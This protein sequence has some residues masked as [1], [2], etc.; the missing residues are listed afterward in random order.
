MAAAGVLVITVAFLVMPDVTLRK[1]TLHD[2]FDACAGFAATGDLAPLAAYGVEWMQSGQTEVQFAVPEGKVRMLLQASDKG[3]NYDV[4]VVVGLLT[5]DVNKLAKPDLPWRDA[6]TSVGEWFAA[7]SADPDAEPWLAA[8]LAPGDSMLAVCPSDGV[9]YILAGGS[10]N[11]LVASKTPTDDQAMH[12]A[13]NRSADKARIACQ[14]V[15]D[16][17]AAG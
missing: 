15:A 9:G 14:M 5:R 1:A 6:K 11:L 8:L 3:G 17:R 10:L 16:V 2:L 4:C 13:A 12:F 7:R